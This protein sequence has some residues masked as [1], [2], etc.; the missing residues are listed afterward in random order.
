MPL[1]TV[2][3]AISIVAKNIVNVIKMLTV[4]AQRL[5]A[6]WL[7][8]SGVFGGLIVWALDFQV[9]IFSFMGVETTTRISIV[10]GVLVGLM[11]Q[12]VYKIM[13][14]IQEKTNSIKAQ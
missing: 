3:L 6:I 1:F 8:L 5:G 2:I 4:K 10:S 7:L 13:K 14:L 9:N 12:D 11:G